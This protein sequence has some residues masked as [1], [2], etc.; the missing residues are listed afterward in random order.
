MEGGL[1]QYQV[2]F[3]CEH[4]T[5]AEPTEE[6]PYVDKASGAHGSSCPKNHRQEV[7]PETS[8]N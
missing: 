4:H 3:F 2:I 8:N 5:A 7:I 6:I 1:A